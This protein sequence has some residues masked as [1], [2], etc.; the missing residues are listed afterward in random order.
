MWK[1]VVT[2]ILLFSPSLF[3][4]NMKPGLW[5]AK[6]V[7]SLNGLQLPASDDQECITAT[8][9]KD[10]KQTIAR[11]L[12]KKGCDLTEWKLKGKSLEA[13]LK[14]QNE[15]F[16]AQ[17]SLK[18]SVTDKSYEL[19]GEAEGAFKMIPSFANIDLKGKWLKDCEKK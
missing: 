9:A 14:C 13:K 15:D 16:Q 19:K 12:K 17:G 8:E 11:E 7:L 10:A 18:G 1:F 6:T 3:A 4:Q 2:G 5:Q